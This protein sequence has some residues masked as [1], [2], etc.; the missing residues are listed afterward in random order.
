MFIEVRHS[1]ICYNFYEFEKSNHFICLCIVSSS[2]K[3]SAN[4]FHTCNKLESKR[5]DWLHSMLMYMYQLFDMTQN[6]SCFDLLLEDLITRAKGVKVKAGP[7]LPRL[8]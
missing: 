5:T 8:Q 6:I 2:P 3:M 7:N 1:N 4:I